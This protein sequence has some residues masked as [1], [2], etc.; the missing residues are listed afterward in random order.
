MPG[1]SPHRRQ[2]A[3]EDTV[4]AYFFSW[5]GG[6]RLGRVSR[7][8]ELYVVCVKPQVYTAR[9]VGLGNLPA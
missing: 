2:D 4:L 5:E 8:T 3:G 6:R 9:G 7:P 1:G